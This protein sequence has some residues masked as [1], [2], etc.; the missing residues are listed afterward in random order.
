MPSFG[1]CFASLRRRCLRMWNRLSGA[2]G[3]IMAALRLHPHERHTV[4]SPGSAHDHEMQRIY[5]IRRAAVLCAGALVLVGLLASVGVTVNN[6]RA[7]KVQGRSYAKAVA[8][9]SKTKPDGHGPLVRQAAPAAQ[10]LAVL[11][12]SQRKAI[13]SKAQTVAEASGNTIRR[14]RYCIS[15]T[16]DIDDITIFESMVFRTLNSS[17]GWPRA[18]ATFSYAGNGCDMTL[19]LAGADTMTSFSEGCSEEYSCRV[20]DKVIIN[21]DRWR[22]GTS[23][24]LKAGGTVERYR[25]LVINHEV[26]HR[27]GHF[28]NEATCSVPGG[29]APVMQQQSMSLGGCS[30]N[31]WPLDSELWVS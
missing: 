2:F 31:E 6:A 21:A 3:G 22:N 17:L 24:W 16:D 25:Q 7:G 30:P 29:A 28:D 13:A 8:S 12:D 15:S 4:W 9:S 10:P 14:Y 27:L 5:R 26:G 19:I 18:G 11:T 20:E 23:N 1:D